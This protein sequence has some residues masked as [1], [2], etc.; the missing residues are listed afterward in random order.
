MSPCCGMAPLDDH[1][2]RGQATK[3]IRRQVGEHA[4]YCAALRKDPDDRVGWL[5]LEGRGDGAL[6]RCVVEPG[7]IE[8]EVDHRSGWQVVPVRL[9]QPSSGWWARL[10]LG[11]HEAFGLVAL[12]AAELIDEKTVR[13]SPEKEKGVS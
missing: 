5:S 3:H 2:G 7:A 10:E 9:D 11:D 1:A 12:G 13:V 6:Q 4:G 8:L